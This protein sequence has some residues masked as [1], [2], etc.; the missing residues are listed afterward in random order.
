MYRHKE[1]LFL[2]CTDVDFT[3]EAHSRRRAVDI[4]QTEK[5]PYE[6]Q[7][8]SGVDHGF[9]LRG[10]MGNPYERKFVFLVIIRLSTQST[11]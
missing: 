10:D 11:C 1:P 3:F 2:S 7:L 9:A 5:K 8:F 6:L 4:L